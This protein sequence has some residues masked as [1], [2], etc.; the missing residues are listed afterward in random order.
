MSNY[1]TT[2]QV[3]SIGTVTL[4]GTTAV[5]LAVGRPIDV[6][7]LIFVVTT[8][9]TAASSI[10][11]SV[12][13]ID[14]TNS[15]AVGTVVI[16]TGMALNA[17]VAV[18]IVQPKTTATTAIDGS[19]TFSGYNPGGPVKVNPGQKLVLTPAANGAAGVVTAYARYYEQG[20]SGDRYQPTAA[21]FTAA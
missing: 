10:A 18:G 3:Q 12:A 14:G 5:P 6:Q 19:K 2:E 20:L 17:V 15:V 7:E 13:N 21:T 8:A 16:P 11:V 9:T 1:F 4:T